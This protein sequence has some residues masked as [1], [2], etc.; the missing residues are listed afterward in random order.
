MTRR[1]PRRR[2]GDSFEIEAEAIVLEL[3]PSGAESQVEAAAANLIERRRH[4]RG[5][6]GITIG[7]AIDQRTD[8]RAVGVLAE[9][10]EQ[11]PALHARSGRV[12][13]EDGIEMVEG[14]QRVVAPRVDLLPEVA[15]SLP[16]DILL[17]GLNSETNRMRRH[18]VLLG[19]YSLQPSLLSLPGRERRMKEGERLCFN[20]R[21]RRLPLVRASLARPGWC[22]FSALPAQ[23][24]RR[25][26]RDSC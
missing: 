14:P 4:L 5:Q 3:E 24:Y 10:A 9:C 8:A 2:R 20:V 16:G 13:H 11:R 26:R 22:E 21:R 17:A 23:P 7:V 6:T 15:H 25:V 18:R 1:V 12:G 19:E